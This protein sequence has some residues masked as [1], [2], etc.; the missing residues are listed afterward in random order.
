MGIE[1][2]DCLSVDYFSDILCIWAYGAQLKLERLRKTFSNQIQVSSRFVPTFAAAR[3]RIAEGWEYR[4]GFAG[5][6]AGQADVGA[7]P[8]PAAAWLFGSGLIGLAG[9][10][11]R[12]S[13]KQA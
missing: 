12:S 11:R 3:Y 4:G 2:S 6:G 1:K 8:V 9:V 10:A 7:V 13:K 5:F